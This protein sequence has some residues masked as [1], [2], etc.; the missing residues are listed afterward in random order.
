MRILSTIL[1]FALF[2]CQPPASP[3]TSAQDRED[4]MAVSKQY[5]EAILAGDLD[6]IRSLANTN[7]ALMPP[8]SGTITGP[9][10]I[11]SYM[12]EGPALSG[13]I[14]PGEVDVSGDLAV[15]SGAYDLTF[16]V[17]DSTQFQDRGKYI[18]VWSKQEDGS[19][20]LHTD[21]W[22]SSMPLA[23]EM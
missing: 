4:A 2:A 21:I 3:D 22:N 6:K 10:G 7:S 1:M 14:T 13:S 20:K 19:W 15:V 5:G 17:N 9:Q 11:A 12:G 18:E 8:G 16:M 23:G